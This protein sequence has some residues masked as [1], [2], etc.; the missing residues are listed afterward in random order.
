MYARTH[1]VTFAIDCRA[2]GEPARSLPVCMH[3][4]ARPCMCTIA[5]ALVYTHV[6]VYI[7][8]F[9]GRDDELDRVIVP[10]ATGVVETIK[11][12]VPGVK[13]CK[14]AL[15][16]VPAPTPSPPFPSPSPSHPPPPY[17]IAPLSPP[18]NETF[19]YL[20]TSFPIATLYTRFSRAGGSSVHTAIFRP[21]PERFARNPGKRVPP[22]TQDRLANAS[23]RQ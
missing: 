2:R 3:A 17:P 18:R 22:F 14:D 13:T 16:K 15:Y 21:F 19:E 23:P 12:C 6:R 1:Y 7:P 5:C 4:Y 20:R 8:P 10:L 11:A 9:V